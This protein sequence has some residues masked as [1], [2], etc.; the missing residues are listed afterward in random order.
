MSETTTYLPTKFTNK[1]DFIE[2]FGD[3]VTG[4]GYKAALSLIEAG[5]IVVY[6]PINATSGS[7]AN[8]ENVPA[9]SVHSMMNSGIEENGI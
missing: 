8:T 4:K 1:D 7:S 5:L 9:G 6:A 2:Y 3:Q